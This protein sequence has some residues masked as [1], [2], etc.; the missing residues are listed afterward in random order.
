MQEK[1]LQVVKVCWLDP[2]KEVVLV[3]NGRD[4]EQGKGPGGMGLEGEWAMN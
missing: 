2:V 4:L 1:E 3:M